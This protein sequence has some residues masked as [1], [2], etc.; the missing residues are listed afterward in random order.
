MKKITLF[1]I[2]LT[3]SVCGSVFAY[4]VK[5]HC[6]L[7]F[8]GKGYYTSV[9]G[10][11]ILDNSGNMP[12][13]IVTPHTDYNH[14]Y[15]GHID[16]TSSTVLSIGIYE[17]TKETSPHQSMSHGV[18]YKT[19]YADYFSVYINTCDNTYDSIYWTPK[20][21]PH[22][23]MITFKDDKG[24]I[25]AQDLLTGEVF[26][27]FYER[28]FDEGAYFSTVEFTVASS[29]TNL[30]WNH[31]YEIGLSDINATAVPE[32]SS[33]MA[34]AFGGAGTAMLVLRRRNK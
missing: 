19:A 18:Y 23:W 27:Y 22:D 11:Y 32:P 7:G 1:V 12:A 5:T 28:F 25:V 34:L 20:Y 13:Q 26:D 33:L 17:V 3:V 9:T 24:N 4:D 14:F 15:F 16:E 10:L 21:N 30:A 8:Y 6:G 29:Y 31:R 2:L